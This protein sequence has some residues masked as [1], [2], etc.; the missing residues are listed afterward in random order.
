MYAYRGIGHTASKP[1]SE[2]TNAG[3]GTREKL[4]VLA[5]RA[6]AGESL[7]HPEDRR[8]GDVDR[9]GSQAMS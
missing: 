1:P 8:Y 4:E 9:S 3:P 7:W 6:A 2:P 5:K